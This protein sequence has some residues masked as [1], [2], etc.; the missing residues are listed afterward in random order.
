MRAS[1]SAA[2]LLEPRD[3]ALERGGALDERRL[4]GPRARSRVAAAPRRPRAPTAAAQHVAEPGLRVALLR[5]VQI[6]R[7]HGLVAAKRRRALFLV[8]AAALGRDDV[9]PALHARQFVGGPAR[10]RLEPDDGLLVAVLLGLQRGDGG[11]ARA[12]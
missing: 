7:G 10:L 3:V 4:L 2:A 1:R 8:G 12:G 9:E 11:L 5:L 6:D